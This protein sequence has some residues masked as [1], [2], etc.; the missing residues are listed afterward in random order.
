MTKVLKVKEVA[1]D[2]GRNNTS[3]TTT[4]DD[5][6]IVAF[7]AHMEIPSTGPMV[8]TFIAECSKF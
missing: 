5:K 7:A 3:F 4:S 6:G 8:I 1:S 2:E